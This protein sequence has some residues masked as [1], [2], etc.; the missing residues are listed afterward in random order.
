MFIPKISLSNTQNQTNFESQW[1]RRKPF[2]SRKYLTQL[3]NSLKPYP[4]LA[5][6]ARQLVAQR[7]QMPRDE[8]A[9]KMSDLILDASNAKPKKRQSCH[10]PKGVITAA[11]L[12]NLEL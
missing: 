4:G 5:E 12:H 1:K 9:K 7:Y 3:V 2:Y 6:E 8:F 11:S 10:L